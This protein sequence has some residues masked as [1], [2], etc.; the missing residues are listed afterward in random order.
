MQAS[1][2]EQHHYLGGPTRRGQQMLRDLESS[3]RENTATAISQAVE[4]RAMGAY[5]RLNAERDALKKVGQARMDGANESALSNLISYGQPRAL[6][7]YYDTPAQQNSYFAPTAIPDSINVMRDEND[8][9]TGF[10]DDTFALGF[11]DGGVVDAYN[12]AMTAS[13][14]SVD[15]LSPEQLARAVS[16][17]KARRVM[18]LQQRQ[19]ARFAQG[20]E[21]GPDEEY[22][23][24][25]MLEGPGHG[26][27]DSI[28]AMIDGTQPARLSKG[29]FILPK[30]IV[31]YYGTKHIDM[32][33][34]KAREA[35]SKAEKKANKGAI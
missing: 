34:E 27:S 8:K 3:K 35:M 5:D 18:E 24:G 26:K 23:G 2:Y 11:A 7:T 4:N 13:L 6:S 31:E 19:G 28:P 25:A 12:K 33:V 16:A 29:E 1:D 17:I 15:R 22:V 14:P 32:L 21:V 9:I 10:Q 20:G 30:D